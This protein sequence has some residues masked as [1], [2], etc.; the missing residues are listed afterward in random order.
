MSTTAAP[1]PSATKINLTVTVLWAPIPWRRHRHRE[2]HYI[3]ALTVCVEGVGGQRGRGGSSCS[4][5]A[6]SPTQ[7]GEELLSE[8]TRQ[9]DVWEEGN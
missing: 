9:E 7:H 5:Q 1:G 2:S 3:T 6:L 4:D 8:G